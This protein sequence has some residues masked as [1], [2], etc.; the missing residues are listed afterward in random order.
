MGIWDD[1]VKLLM[2]PKEADGSWNFRP[3]WDAGFRGVIAEINYQT[4]ANGAFVD[5]LNFP[6]LVDKVYRDTGGQMAVVGKHNINEHWISTSGASLKQWQDHNFEVSETYPEQASLLGQ[7][8]NKHMQ[9]LILN[10]SKWWLTWPISFDKITTASWGS[11]IVVKTMEQYVANAKS[12]NPKIKTA[13]PMYWRH[14]VENYHA[15]VGNTLYTSDWW[16]AVDNNVMGAA[17]NYDATGWDV[18]LPRQVLYPGGEYHN[19]PPLSCNEL[20]FW[21]YAYGVNFPGLKGVVGLVT[22]E[23]TETAFYSLM[24]L[25][26]PV[27]LPDPEPEPEPEEPPMTQEKPFGID[28]SRW[29]GKADWD[30][31]AAHSPKV[32]F[33]VFRATISWGYK[34]IQLAP[35]MAGA[36]K[37][38]ILR[39]AYHVIY[40]KQSPTRQMDNFFG[41]L[42]TDLGELP[43][44]LD[45]ELDHDAHWSEIQTT[46]KACADIIEGRTG[47]KPIIYSRKQW[48]DDFMS[49]HG[50]NVPPWINEYDWWLA[51]YLTSG[52][53]H[54]GPAYP[55]KGV[56]Q[57]KVLFHQTADHTPGFGVESK[58]MDYD[59]WQGTVEQLMDYA[60]VAG[61]EPP[62][63]PEPNEAEKLARL[64]AAHPEL[65]W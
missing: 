14:L 8:K 33:A 61:E 15:A 9:A 53:E 29:Q 32:E 44:V 13:F 7:V 48:I 19:W 31:I 2:L 10:Y 28:I 39:S 45:V 38:G 60:G 36:K 17:I 55:P 21:K 5:N 51:L 6:A 26:M 41:A 37:K 1:K 57:S 23:Y 64:W 59:R 43:L 58:M 65:H 40:P 30:V 54:P 46:V 11:A 3:A 50:H 34:D 16:E 4:N 63:E 22:S 18:P 35:N 56:S 42:G 52:K 20:S 62:P 47:R 25:P 49:N 12:I 27:S 24:G